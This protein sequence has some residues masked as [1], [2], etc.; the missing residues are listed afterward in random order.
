MGSANRIKGG[1]DRRRSPIILKDS[2]G[3]GV[4]SFALVMGIFLSLVIVLVLA[5]A[6]T[7]QSET[8]RAAASR[9]YDIYQLLNV[10]FTDNTALKADNWDNY[11][12]GGAVNG[13]NASGYV[14]VSVTDNADMYENGWFMQNLVVPSYSGISSMDVT[15]KYRIISAE[16]IKPGSDNRI[17]ITV[18]VQ[19]PGGDN[20]TVST[21]NDNVVSATWTTVDNTANIIN[22]AGTYKL[23]LRV[24]AKPD[25]TKL[26]GSNIQIGLD[27]AGLTVDSY[28]E[29]AGPSPSSAPIL[30]L[31]PLFWA[32]L[33]LVGAGVGALVI[34]K[35]ID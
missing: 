28:T 4:V 24:D 16:N 35:S 2:K 26:F 17:S 27:D 32:I 5:P 11:A 9:G 12:Q 22:A 6:L 19:R 13:W 7:S 3:V 10:S 15:F 30:G 20:V 25:S 34:I 1:A 33:A 18:V 14:T 21:I 8:A 31:A 29:G 23:F